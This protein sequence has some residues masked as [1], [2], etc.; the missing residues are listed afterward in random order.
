MQERPLTSCQTPDKMLDSKSDCCDQLQIESRTHPRLPVGRYAR[1]TDRPSDDMGTL[2]NVMSEGTVG[3]NQS[4]HSSRPNPEFDRRTYFGTL[5]PK[6]RSAAVARKR[7]RCVFGNP[8]ARAELVRY[9][10]CRT[11]QAG[12]IHTFVLLAP[13]RH[14]NSYSGRRSIRIWERI[15]CFEQLASKRFQSARQEIPHSTKSIPSPGKTLR[16]RKSE[17]IENSDD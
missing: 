7:E 14:S 4:V 5:I 8:S 11:S 17:R 1:S 2:V 9:P 6:V 3:G 12:R 13:F 10:Q 16:I 15:Q